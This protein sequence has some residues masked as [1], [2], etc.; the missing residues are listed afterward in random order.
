M[1]ESLA[2][3]FLDDLELSGRSPHTVRAY[4]QSLNH[5]VRFVGGDTDPG[6]VD[7]RTIRRFLAYRRQIGDAPGTLATRYIAMGRFWS[8]LADEQEVPTNIVK[9]VKR[10]REEIKPVALLSEDQLKALLRVEGKTPF[11]TIRNKTIIMVLIDTGIRVGELCSLRVTDVD[12]D[13]RLLTVRGKTGERTVPFGKACAAALRRFMRHR[14]RHPRA[15]SHWLFIGATNGITASTV[16]KM[17]QSYG[18]QVGIPGLHPHRFRHSFVHNLLT[19]GATIVDV[20]R[21]GGWSDPSQLWYRYGLAGAG[22]RAIASHRKFSPGD[23][24]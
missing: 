3:E 10:P 6:E 12:F 15:G 11:L 16:R 23:R 17:F 24:L 1:L 13:V 22:E 7:R 9:E 21:L 2:R 20:Q 8:W 4:R 19:A 18:E 14:G 5:L